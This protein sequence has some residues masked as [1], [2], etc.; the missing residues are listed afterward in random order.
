[1][2]RWI[3]APFMLLI[4]FC[5]MAISAVLSLPLAILKWLFKPTKGWK[6]HY[7]ET[8]LDLMHMM[9]PELGHETTFQ[10]QAVPLRS[11]FIFDILLM[12]DSRESKKIS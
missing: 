6:K 4:L 1:M 7:D 10:Y 8:F 2:L 12:Y 5:W 3:F 11:C 9:F